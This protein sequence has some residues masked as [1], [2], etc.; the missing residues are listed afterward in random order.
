MKQ[1]ICAIIL[2]AGSA[3][4]MGKLKQLLPFSDRPMLEHVIDKVLQGN[5]V[6]V[7]TVIGNGAEEIQQHISVHDARFHWLVNEHYQMGQSTSLQ[8]ALHHILPYYKNI[9]IF[10]GDLPFV[11]IETIEKVALVGSESLKVNEH[12]F[13]VRPTYHHMQGHPVFIGHMTETLANKISGDQGLKSIR[14]EFTNKRIIPVENE[15][16]IFDIDTPEDYKKAMDIL[17]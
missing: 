3:N 9:M 14:H 8:L 12:P 4:R 11:T 10:L 5:F 17:K 6:E 7:Y 2:A 13:I 1:A 16:V 15:G